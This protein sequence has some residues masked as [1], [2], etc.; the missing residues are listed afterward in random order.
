MC[1]IN[2]SCTI[3]FFAIIK[4]ITNQRMALI[5]RNSIYRITQNKIKLSMCIKENNRT[6][7]KLVMNKSSLIYDI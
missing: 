6:N 1:N 4:I 5:H 2:K 7:N 3:A